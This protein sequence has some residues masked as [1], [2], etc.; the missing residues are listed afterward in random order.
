[1]VLGE[2]TY[3]HVTDILILKLV[4]RLEEILLDIIFQRELDFGQLFK[5]FPS[6][7][8]TFG[9]VKMRCEK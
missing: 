3:Q 9:C 4:Q 1:M 7:V 5:G 2:E 8:Q 6:F